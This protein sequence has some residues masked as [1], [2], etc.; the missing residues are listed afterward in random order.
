MKCPM[1]KLESLSKLELTETEKNLLQKEIQ[2][3]LECMDKL[4]ELNTQGIQPMTQLEETAILYRED[5]EV[6]RYTSE[7]MLANAPAH[8]EDMFVVP[9]TIQRGE[10]CN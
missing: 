1:E 2:S 10:T 4:G 9:N 6:G 8:R 5:N 7:E 3:L